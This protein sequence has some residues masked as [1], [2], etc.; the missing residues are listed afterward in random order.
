MRAA[1]LHLT[2]SCSLEY[3]C[4]Y[5]PS[6]RK[7][8]SEHEPYSHTNAR[9]RSYHSNTSPV[10]VDAFEFHVLIS[11]AVHLCSSRLLLFSIALNK[12]ARARYSLSTARALR[13]HLSRAQN[14]ARTPR[15]DSSF[16][17]RSALEKNV[18]A[19]INIPQARAFISI[20][21]T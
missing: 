21:L 14:N 3:F 19:L 2:Q 20:V 16:L 6:S 18:S 4:C 1:I 11:R 10:V 15:A 7:Y 12:R 13:S 9:R 17:P 8:S 5:L